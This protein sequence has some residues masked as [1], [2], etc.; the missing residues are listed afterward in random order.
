[1]KKSMIF[2][3]VTAGGTTFSSPVPLTIP[4]TIPASLAASDAQHKQEHAAATAKIADHFSQL[5]TNFFKIVQNHH[6]S[7]EV[8][9]NIAGIFDNIIKIGL[10]CMKRGALS[11]DSSPEEIERFIAQLIAHLEAELHEQ[12]GSVVVKRSQELLIVE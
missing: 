5:V 8:G 10:E 1:M 6:N 7:A 2:M 4:T 11:A 12:L 3:L 9:Y